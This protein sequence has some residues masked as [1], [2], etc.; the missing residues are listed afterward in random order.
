MPEARFLE[1]VPSAGGLIEDVQPGPCF[2]SENPIRSRGC[3]CWWC[4]WDLLFL[5]FLLVLLFLLSLC[6]GLLAL[7]LAM[8][9]DLFLE[10]NTDAPANVN[11]SLPEVH[12]IFYAL[13]AIVFLVA[14]CVLLKRLIVAWRGR[15]GP[16]SA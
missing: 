6:L 14:F 9:W 8:S 4:Q 15:N 3:C 2:F 5:T 13:P 16:A 7:V 10:V 12:W 1:D 11:V